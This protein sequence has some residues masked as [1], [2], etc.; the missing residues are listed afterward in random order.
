MGYTITPRDL[1]KPRLT[2]FGL[3]YA[4]DETVS[5]EHLIAYINWLECRAEMSEGAV[6]VLAALRRAQERQKECA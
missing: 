1:E 5:K 3:I 4:A 2:I 6:S